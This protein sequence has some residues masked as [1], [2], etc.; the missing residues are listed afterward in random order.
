MKH[1]NETNIIKNTVIKQSKW[2]NG[3]LKPEHKKTINMT[4][5]STTEL[6]F[7]NLQ[8]V[9]PMTENDSSIFTTEERENV[10]M[11]YSFEKHEIVVLTKTLYVRGL[12]MCPIYKG[13][14]CRYFTFNISKF[15]C[16]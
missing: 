8:P 13:D 6:S 1:H 14:A 12:T 5:M 11:L 15:D 2:L 4:I 9:Y 7:V 10:N 3:D 16:V